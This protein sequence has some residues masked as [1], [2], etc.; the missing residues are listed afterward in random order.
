MSG[1]LTRHSPA[2][3]IRK[4]LDEWGANGWQVFATNEPDEPDQ[5]VTVYDVDGASDGRSMCDGELW[6]HWGIQVRVRSD[7]HPDGWLQMNAIRNFFSMNV[8]QAIV[9]M[10][11]GSAYIVW[12]ITNIGQIL[13]LGQD[14]PRTKRSLFTLNC[15]VP[16]REVTP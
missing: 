14:K 13:P 5:T 8:N 3:I 1:P 6:N 11:D 9:V 16:I 10:D 4:L 12:C 2:E 15:R 7:E